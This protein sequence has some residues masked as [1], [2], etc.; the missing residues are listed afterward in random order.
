MKFTAASPRLFGLDTLRAFAV[1]VVIL[2]HLTIF[3]ELP[4]RILP[5][6]Y[7]GWMGVDLFFV[8]SGFLIGQQV[9]K[10]YVSGGRF[11]IGEFY[12]RRAYRILPA[13]FAVLSVYF[14]VPAW[15][16]YPRLAPLWKFLT[17]T[18]NFGFSFSSRGFSHA[19]SLCVEEHF[20]LLLPLLVL[21]LM[22]RPSARVTIAAIVSVVVFGVAL[23]AYLIAR[24]P[25]YIWTRIYYPS[26]TRLDGL[27][28]GVTLAAVRSFRPVSWSSLMR[29]GHALFFSGVFCVGCVVWMFRGLDLG[30]DTGPAMWGVVIGFPLLSLGLGLITASSVSVNGLLARVKTPGAE[31]VATLAFSLY[32]THK[33]VG[34]FVMQRFPQVTTSQGPASWVLYAVACFSVAW[35]LHVAVERPFLVLRDRALRRTSVAVLEAEMMKEPAL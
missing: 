29:R 19:W 11:S 13:Y 35:L 15:R 26:Y 28:V 17:F 20:Y 21:L 14:L 30:N 10:P 24:Y 1:V 6:T 16:E 7:F 12:V 18:M 32:L 34:H 22:R 23:R 3:G 4:M 9:L 5:V 27:V 8:L 2:Y 31:V 33:A 25:G